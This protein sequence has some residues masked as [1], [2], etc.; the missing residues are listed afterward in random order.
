VVVTVQDAVFPGEQI[1]ILAGKLFPARAFGASHPFANQEKISVGD[2]F[3]I[4]LCLAASDG[5]ALQGAGKFLQRLQDRMLAQIRERQPDVVSMMERVSRK[6][7]ALKAA[8]EFFI[9]H[10]NYE[11]ALALAMVHAA[12]V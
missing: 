8:D 1:S 5:E 4:K 9:A 3:I 12:A 6:G 10:G 11:A 2:G 7:V